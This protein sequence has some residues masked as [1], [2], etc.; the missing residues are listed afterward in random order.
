MSFLFEGLLEYTLHIS[1][2]IVNIARFPGIGI[3]MWGNT[4]STMQDFRIQIDGNSKYRTSTTDPTPQTYMQWYQSPV[5][6][7]GQHTL[8]ISDIHGIALDFILITPGPTTLLGG[9]TL[10]LDDSHVAITYRG[11]GW[12]NVAGVRYREFEGRK[13]T[14]KPFQNGTHQTSTEGDSFSFP[15][16]G[17]TSR[18]SSLCSQ[19]TKRSIIQDRLSRYTGSYSRR[20]AQSPSPIPS[21]MLPASK[22]HTPTLAASP[23]DQSSSTIS[24]STLGHFCLE[25]TS[26]MSLSI[27]SLARY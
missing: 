23:M 26:L 10:I 19:S 20:K 24:F 4:A 2:R 17:E 16:S 6:S 11:T 3:A 18:F 9:K 22:E 5:L 12:K 7:D 27:A 25:I 15:Y 1:V 21:I 14:V 8:N 13:S